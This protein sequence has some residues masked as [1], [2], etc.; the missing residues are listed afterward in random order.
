MQQQ[1]VF[2]LLQY[3][4]DTFVLYSMTCTGGCNYSFTNSWRWT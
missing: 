4:F 1:A 2:I 3:P